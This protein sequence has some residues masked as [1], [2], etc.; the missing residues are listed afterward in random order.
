MAEPG[1]VCEDD[2][3]MGFA[4]GCVATVLFQQGADQSPSRKKWNSLHFESR[5][6]PGK[7]KRIFPTA[8]CEHAGCY[9]FSKLEDGRCLVA[10]LN[11][12]AANL[13]S[14]WMG[15]LAAYFSHD[16]GDR[17]GQG[18]VKKNQHGFRNFA[19][20]H[21]NEKINGGS[22]N[23][24]LMLQV[25]YHTTGRKP[26]VPSRPKMVKLKNTQPLLGFIPVCY[27]LQG[28]SVLALRRLIKK[29]ITFY[30]CIFNV[31]SNENFV[32]EFP[33]L[34]KKFHDKL[35]DL[36]CAGKV[37]MFPSFNTVEW[38]VHNIIV[39]TACTIMHLH[40]LC[41]TLP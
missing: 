30:N 13:N 25:W 29:D 18:A 2:D 33:K 32:M 40:V 23:F 11:Q 4:E 17:D 24:E 20:K 19:R 35:I 5:K 38:N 12:N 9:Q 26:K 27:V 22:V 41:C 15:H 14:T 37:P 31:D 34:E 1:E 10:E 7:R 28:T 16:E 8:K 3:P 21:C 36:G 6:S 39:C